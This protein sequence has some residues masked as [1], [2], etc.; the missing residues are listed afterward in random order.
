[1]SPQ[2]IPYV[3]Q[4]WADRNGTTPTDWTV[5]DTVSG[6]EVSSARPSYASA[7][8]VDPLWTVSLLDNMAHYVEVRAPNELSALA[9]AHAADPVDFPMTVTSDDVIITP[10]RAQ[11]LPTPRPIP[12]VEDVPLD[13]EL[14]QRT[15]PGSTIDLAQQR[16]TPGTFTGAWQVLDLY[17]GEE[18]YRFSGIGN[19]Q[20]D[21]NRVAGQWVRNNNI[22][23]PTEVYPIMS[24]SVTESFINALTKLDQEPWTLTESTNNFEIKKSSLFDK[25]V[26]NKSEQL[27]DLANKIQEFL[28]FKMIN[29]GQP[30]GNDSPFIAAGPLGSAIPKLR[31][32]HLTRDL[33]LYYTI[34]GRNPTVIKLY[35]VFNHHESGTGTPKNINKQKNLA[36][37]LVNQE[38]AETKNPNTTYRLWTAPVKIKQPTYT[39]YI[40][41]AVTAQNAQLARQ[42]MKAQYGVADWEIGSVKEVKV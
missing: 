8:A 25:T 14:A 36:R 2:Q 28:K 27:P 10:R 21:A 20:E 39:G 29:P 34:E 16:A 12:G 32:A 9:A 23:V 30:W 42:L 7:R 31:H 22:A 35:G 4:A 26:Q 37:Q 40:D 3:L 18:L 38:V 11:Q 24:E 17:T 13:L 33:S 41:V 19:S 1:V 15:V 6:I 5:I